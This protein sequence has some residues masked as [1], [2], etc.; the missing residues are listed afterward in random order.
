MGVPLLMSIMSVH[1]PTPEQGARLRRRLAVVG[2]W[3]ATVLVYGIGDLLTTIT[4]LRTQNH[5][6]ETNVVLATIFDTFGRP[7]VITLKVSVLL[8]AALLSVAAF[9]R[10]NDHHLYYGPPTILAIMGTAATA[11][12]VQLLLTV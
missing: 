12:N 9:T 6:V 5:L 11:H 2:L 8:F 10:W 1:P 3:L 7:G 4:I